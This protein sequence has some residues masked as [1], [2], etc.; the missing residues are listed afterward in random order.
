[1][2]EFQELAGGWVND[3][4]DH[5]GVCCGVGGR[6]CNALGGGSETNTFVDYYGLDGEGTVAAPS[7]VSMGGLGFGTLGGVAPSEV[8]MVGLAPSEVP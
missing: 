4:V 5:G 3:G 2:P 1:V 7:R 6:W 8:P